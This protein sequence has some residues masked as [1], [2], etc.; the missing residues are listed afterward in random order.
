MFKVMKLKALANRKFIA[1]VAW[2][3]LSTAVVFFLDISGTLQPIQDNAYDGLFYMRTKLRPAHERPESPVVLVAI[4]DQTFENKRYNIPQILWHHY[5]SDIILALA[6]GGAKGIGLDMLLPRALFDDLV[7]NYSRTWLRTFVYAKRKGSPVVT[8]VVQLAG[9]M[10]TPEGRYLQII[11]PENIGLFNLTVDS[12]DF[13]RRQRLYFPSADHPEEGLYSVTFLLAKIW[14]PHLKLPAESIFIDYD[15]SPTPFPVFSFADVHQRALDKDLE[16]FKKNFNNKIVFIGET[17]S[18]TMDRHATPLY[19]LAET[20]HKR[21]AGV[22]ILAQAMDTILRQDF[23][24]EISAGYRFSLYLALAL[25]ICAVT[26]YGPSR[27]LPFLLLFL[28]F[29]YFVVSVM[30]F[31]KY[32]ILPVVG[33]VAVMILSQVLSFSYRHW[34]VDWEKRKMR[35]IFQRYLPPKVVEKIL[36]T[37]DRDFFRGENKRLCLMFTDI[38]GFTTYSEKREPTEVVGRLNEYFEAMSA[39]IVSEGGVVDKFLGDGIMAFFGAFDYGKPPSLA[40]A[41]AALK[42]IDELERLNVKWKAADQESFRIGI[43]IHTGVVKVGNIGSENKM[44]YTVIGDAVNL[45]S[46]L[47]DKTKDLRETIVI[48][49]DVYHDLSEAAE[50]EDRGVVDIKGRSRTKVFGLKGL[51]GEL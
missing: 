42:M 13:V 6:D 24:E 40:G 33:G 46:R 8:G 14:Q 32:L 18:M 28:V 20:G 25:M 45:A 41:R 22:N 47:Q 11:G 48:S 9:R 10:I 4:D 3:L 36:V 49:E 16:F 27:D 39:V 43:G 19:F 29:V 38:R 31:F 37:K 1:L 26:I 44:E 23:F 15:P 35:A 21:T 51:R 7:P 50:V 5:F 17:D 34:V 30:A 12:D 2:T